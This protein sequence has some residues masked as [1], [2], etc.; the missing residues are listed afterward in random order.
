MANIK[1]GYYVT[2]EARLR[3]KRWLVNQEISFSEFCRRA[4][5]CRQYMDRIINGKVKVTPESKK[6]FEKGGYDLL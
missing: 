4:G 3:F 2:K 1:D 5:A 6:W